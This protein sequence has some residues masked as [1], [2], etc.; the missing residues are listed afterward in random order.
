MKNFIPLLVLFLLFA[1]CTKN[2]NASPKDEEP[3]QLSEPLELETFPQN[4]D[5]VLLDDDLRFLEET[6]SEQPDPE[7][8]EIKASQILESDTLKIDTVDSINY[9][10]DGGTFQDTIYVG[11]KPVGFQSTEF[12]RETIQGHP[13]LCVIVR[14]QLQVTPLEISAAHR[15]IETLQ[16][17]LINCQ[18][19]IMR[20]DVLIDQTAVVMNENLEIT[21]TI[22]EQ[23]TQKALPWKIGART[24]GLC[25]IQVSLFQN[26]MQDQEERRLSFYDPTRSAIVETVLIAKNIE[27]VTLSGQ[28]LTLRRIETVFKAPQEQIPITLWTDAVGNI[29]RMSLPF[30]ETETLVTTRVQ[31]KK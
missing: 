15:S 21:T 17:E 31:R 16:G 6:S 26:P 9:L 24:G 10:E 1:G 13:V 4:N 7:P 28:T 2:E 8:L 14:N 11:S 27:K 25:A 18:S 22:E 29:A 5:G 19:K 12:S 30:R 20:N 3:V 23:A